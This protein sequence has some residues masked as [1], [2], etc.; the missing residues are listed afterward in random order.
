MGGRTKETLPGN[1]QLDGG[2]G[3]S[4]Q[5]KAKANDPKSVA[6][7]DGEAGFAVETGVYLL[8]ELKGGKK[9]GQIP[10]PI[11]EIKRFQAGERPGQPKK[12]KQGQGYTKHGKKSSCR[13]N[14][15]QT[16]KEVPVSSRKRVERWAVQVQAGR[17]KSRSEKK[18]EGTA[19]KRIHG[20][21]AR[22]SAVA[23]IKTRPARHQNCGLLL[24]CWFLYPIQSKGKGSAVELQRDH[25]GY[26]HGQIKGGHSTAMAT[27]N[28]LIRITQ[29]WAWYHN[30]RGG[31]SSSGYNEK[32]LITVV[33][34]NVL[35]E[36]GGGGGKKVPAEFSRRRS[37]GG[38]RRS[39]RRKRGEP[40]GSGDKWLVLEEVGR[41]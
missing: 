14:L 23:L 27:G 25:E 37:R 4:G 31:I 18:G 13:S 21:E 12:G 11:K 36:E 34:G 3:L 29:R 15:K 40:W 17:G 39:V 30:I 2:A 1:W 9:K 33:G 32:K 22:P 26:R 10:C 16:R 28:G 24:K 5:E 41:P 38:V 6:S 7:W 19:K 35:G 8:S 20:G